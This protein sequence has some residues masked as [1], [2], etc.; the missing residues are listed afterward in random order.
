VTEAA[1][2][3][4]DEHGERAVVVPHHDA[5]G[6]SAGVLLARRARGGVLHVESPWSRPLP[7]VAAAVVA[8]WGVR[9]VAGP[10]T[11][12]YVDHH[13]A[14]EPVDGV[15]VRP[16]ATAETST[17]VLAWELLGC[18][19]QDG[20]LALLGAAGDLGDAAFDL[21]LP[22][23]RSRTATKRLATL[24]TAA[25][26]VRSGPVAEAFALLAGAGDER[27]ALAGP[28]L[29][30]LEEARASAGAARARAMKTAPVVGPDAA[31]IRFSDV[32]R[33]R[34]G[35]ARRL[36]RFHVEKLRPAPLTR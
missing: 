36:S 24:V 12:L 10:G 20:W 11:V 6:L 31:L 19:P 5:D 29:A 30:A 4:L 2:A 9:P 32:R 33:L 7:G 8:D 21:G 27:E 1:G 15:V 17:S 26:R 25:G 23:P 3:W 34:R 35:D 13:A 18:P 16:Q 14:P 28:A 22:A